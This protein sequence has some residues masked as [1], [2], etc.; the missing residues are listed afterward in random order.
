MLACLRIGEQFP[1]VP[2]AFEW[3][4]EIVWRVRREIPPM[5]EAEFTE[6]AGWFAANEERL[7]GLADPSSLFDVGRG[8]KTCCW[9]IRNA[10]RAGPRAEGAGESAEDIRQLRTRYGA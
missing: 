8:R 5:T 9:Y 6:L 1:D 7:A 4:T 2:V 10:L 3:L